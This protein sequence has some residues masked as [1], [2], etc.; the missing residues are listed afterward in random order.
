MKMN[1]ITTKYIQLRQWLG[2][3]AAS[4]VGP[5]AGW[6]G[7][8]VAHCPRCQERLAKLG[9]VNLALTLIKSQPHTLEL[10]ARANT[11]AIGKLKNALRE[12]P[13]AEMLKVKKPEPVY[14]ERLTRYAH[15]AVNVAACI[16]IVVLMKVGIFGSIQRID[17]D[18]S[19]IV[20]KYYTS[21]ISQDLGG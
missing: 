21:K 5:E 12:V 8:H 18:G 1:K 10:L 9:R 16:A 19:Q 11:L 17:H 6:V 13:Q 4:C 7:N 3:A 20:D 15:S 2:S 14:Y